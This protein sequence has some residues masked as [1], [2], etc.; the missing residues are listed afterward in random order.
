M[1]RCVGK[2]RG[3]HV[4]VCSAHRK[5][6]D[7]SV[8]VRISSPIQRQL[9]SGNL[10]LVD[11]YEVYFY[12][13]AWLLVHLHLVGCLS[14]RLI[15]FYGHHGCHRRAIMF[16]CL[17]LFFFFLRPTSTNF[18]LHVHMYEEYCRHGNSRNEPYCP[19]EDLRLRNLRVPNYY[20]IFP[21]N[22][23]EAHRLYGTSRRTFQDR[24][25]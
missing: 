23:R 20:S 18:K 6:R 7:E 22:S 24:E 16:C 14:N 1:R 3:Q 4:G 8:L 2:S 13:T 11:H 19:F 5:L 25:K 10:Y 21:K 9:F 17:T 12:I 15:N